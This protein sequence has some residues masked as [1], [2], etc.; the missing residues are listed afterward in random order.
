MEGARDLAEKLQAEGR[1]LVLDQ[2]AN[3]DNPIAHY[4]ST[5]PEIWRSRPR[6]PSPISSAPWAPPAPSWAARVPQGA[7]PGGADHRP[8]TD[9]RLGHSGHP[10]LARGIPAEDLRR[11]PG[12]PRVDMAQQ[13]AEDTTRRLA[14]EEGIFCGVSS[15]GAVAAMLRL[16]REVENAVMVAIICDRGDRYLSTG[17]FDPT[18]V[19]EK[20]NRGLRFQP[21]GGTGPQVPWARSSA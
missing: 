2:F 1:G 19:Q 9:G 8:A 10:P 11:H 14:R 12:R 3:G 21:T 6:A 4:T 18:D 16:S 15:G 20:S 17:L 13:E 5:G 7:E